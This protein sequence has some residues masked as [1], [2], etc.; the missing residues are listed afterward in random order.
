MASAAPATSS[1]HPLLRWLSRPNWLWR[2]ARIG[3]ISY[4][5]VL[6][7][8]AWFENSLIF[9]P[10][11]DPVEY[12]HPPGLVLDDVFFSASDGTRLHGWYVPHAQPKAVVLFSHGNGGN[13]SHR[14]DV[15]RTLHQLGAAV[16]I[17][18]YRGYG[19]SEGSPTEAGV[20]SDARAARAWLAQRAG[21]K[22]A[23]IVQMG[24]S[25]GGAVAVD[26]AAADGARGLILE[27]TFSSLPDV[28]AHHYSWAPVKL[29]MRSRFDSVAKIGKYH[30]PLL[31][32]H[33]DADTI[34][35]Y[36]FSQRLFAAANEP[37]R[38]VTIPRGDHNDPRTPQFDRALKVFLD[39]LPVEK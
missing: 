26:L 29:L 2:G 9:F 5:G 14:E 15:L 22:E 23:D 33:G 25:L 11:R 38:F 30:G 35:P 4:L 16:F 6:L 36:Q 10:S 18:D 34:V 37:K 19:R 13:L 7:L 21:V 17:Y 1:R 28:A 27:N 24:E 12:T 3:L 39:E 8:M 20:M 32:F 31:Q